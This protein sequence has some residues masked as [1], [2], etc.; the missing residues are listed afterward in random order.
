MTDV[1]EQW[2]TLGNG[3]WSRSDLNNYDVFPLPGVLR[4]GL[5]AILLIASLSA[6]TTFT[7]SIFIT[8]RLIFWRSHSSRYLGHNQY[9]I[10][11]YQLILTDLQHSLGYLISVKCYGAFVAFIF[12]IW[13]FLLSMVIIPIAIHG[14]E[15]MVPSGAWCWINSK[16]EPLRL[17]THYLWIFVAEFGSVSLY[18]IVAFRL[19]RTINH[20]AILANRNTERMRLVVR[21]MVIYPIAYIMLSLPIAAGRMAMVRGITPSPVYFCA[22]AAIIT[23]SGIVDVTIYTLTRRKLI[24]NADPRHDND[25]DGGISAPRVNRGHN[26]SQLGTETVVPGNSTDNI[27]HAGSEEAPDLAQTYRLTTFEAIKRTS[28]S[29]SD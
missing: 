27:L 18:A 5:I 20:S 25:R 6:I 9:I 17:Y 4:K 7:L 22:S 1:S 14:R 29:I 11:I 12:S 15:A 10:L 13:A 16:Y 2:K 26:V 19:R 28:L 3:L 8:Y 24:M 23:S 21:C